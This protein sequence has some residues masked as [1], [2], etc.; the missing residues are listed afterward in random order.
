MFIATDGTPKDLAPLGA[1][2]GSGR[3]PMQV[4]AVALL[5]SEESKKGPPAINISPLMGRRGEMFCCTCKLN[6]RFLIF[7]RVSPKLAIFRVL[8]MGNEK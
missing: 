6:P 1:K 7:H 5:W 4:K 8:E 3:L 2:S